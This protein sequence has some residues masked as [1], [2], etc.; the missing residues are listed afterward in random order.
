MNK[1]LGLTACLLAITPSMV[2]ADQIYTFENIF[3][4]SEIAANEI[5]F[6]VPVG[7]FAM[8]TTTDNILSIDVKMTGDDCRGEDTDEPDV[9]AKLKGDVLRFLIMGEDCKSKVNVIMPEIFAIRL[10][11]GVGE[12]EVEAFNDMDIEVGVGSVDVT[13]NSQQ[14]GRVEVEAGVGE[15]DINLDGGRVIESERWF[16]NKS[17]TWHGDGDHRLDV[18]VGVGEIDVDEY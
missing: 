4:A 10:E 8:E 15:A 18:T 16:I 14:F 3:E 6:E 1:E 2:M 5:R 7:S 13:L 9:S 17:I 12:V 11:M